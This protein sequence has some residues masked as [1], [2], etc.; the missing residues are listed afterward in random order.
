MFASAFR[1][2]SRGMRLFSISLP[3]LFLVSEFAYAQQAASSADSNS[4]T[5]T[6]TLIV[7]QPVSGATTQPGQKPAAVATPAKP[8]APTQVTTPAPI[9]VSPVLAKPAANAT[10]TKAAPN[11][12]NHNGLSSQSSGITAAAPPSLPNKTIVGSSLVKKTSPALTPGKTQGAGTLRPGCPTCAPAPLAPP[13]QPT[14]IQSSAPKPPPVGPPSSKGSG[15]DFGSSSNAPAAS[16]SPDAT[17]SNSTPTPQTA[18]QSSSHSKS[19]PPVQ[20]AAPEPLQLP[21]PAPS[22]RDP[23]LPDSKSD[24]PRNQQSAPAPPPLPAGH[25]NSPGKY[26][27]PKNEDQVRWSATG[28]ILYGAGFTFTDSDPYVMYAEESY[29]FVE[30]EDRPVWNILG[31]CVQKVPADPGDGPEQ[32]CPFQKLDK[33]EI[34]LNYRVPLT[35]LQHSANTYLFEDM[36]LT[37]KPVWICLGAKGKTEWRLLNSFIGLESAS[38]DSNRKNMTTVVLPSHTF[39]TADGSESSHTPTKDVV[40][41]DRQL[42]M[43]TL[44][45]RTFV[46]TRVNPAIPSFLRWSVQRY[47]AVGVQSIFFQWLLLGLQGLTPVALVGWFSRKLIRRKQS[48]IQAAHP[49]KPMKIAAGARG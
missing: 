30:P 33:S 24:L 16:A 11:Q 22:S 6:R 48:A 1:L 2:L 18:P 29:Q 26:G 42:F 34:R 10:A 36:A 19:A 35:S 9:K 37:S 40:Q 12:P 21:A 45:P 27:F 13:I 31:Y 20:T 47:L 4:K 14:T 32:V 3:V 28:K 7:A 39:L 49:K 46:I 15:R 5:K 25:R 43:E 44:D 41:F 8:A 38:G 17:A 23:E